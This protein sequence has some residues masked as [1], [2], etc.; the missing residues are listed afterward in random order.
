MSP[1]AAEAFPE[2]LVTHLACEDMMV[3]GASTVAQGLILWVVFML[4]HL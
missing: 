2:P 3:W 1:R 4:S